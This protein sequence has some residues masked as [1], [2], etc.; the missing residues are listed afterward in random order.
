M[1][2]TPRSISPSPI[3]T[4]HPHS[5]GE[6]VGTRSADKKNDGSSPLAW[7]T[8]LTTDIRLA[9]VRF[10][11]TRVGNTLRARRWILLGSV[12]PHSRGE[13]DCP[14]IHRI[15]RDGSSPLAWGTL[16]RSSG[17]LLHGRFI[18]TR[19]GNTYC[20]PGHAIRHAVHP[21]SRGEHYAAL[22]QSQQALGSSP[23][24]WGTQKAFG[25]DDEV[26]RFIPTRVGNTATPPR[27][28]ISITVHPHSR[29]EHFSLVLRTG[30]A[31]GSSPL[32][33]GTHDQAMPDATKRRFIPTRVGNTLLLAHCF[34]KQ[35]YRP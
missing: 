19:V 2:N 33:W 20:S 26:L 14:L 18:P 1:G 22:D 16:W 7:G 27:C 9:S 30:R 8:P 11:P 13:H 32:A 21:H 4:V 35:I 24:A 23:L 25:I 10:I 6:H 3:Q 15:I 17:A 5:R 29:G 34:T 28:D 31:G 12:H